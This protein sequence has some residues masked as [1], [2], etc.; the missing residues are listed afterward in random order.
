MR[1]ERNLGTVG[2]MLPTKSI[3]QQRVVVQISVQR[4]VCRVRP[5]VVSSRRITKSC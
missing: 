5:A 2:R 1:V 3:A 4:V